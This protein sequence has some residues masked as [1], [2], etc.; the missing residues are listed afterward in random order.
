M[1]EK[2]RSGVEV[3]E[4]GDGPMIRF[5]EKGD[6]V[7]ER[8]TDKNLDNKKNEASLLESLR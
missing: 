7:L 1:K 3:R 4:R 5:E 8:L 6:V 2:M